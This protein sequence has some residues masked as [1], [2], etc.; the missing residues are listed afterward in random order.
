[1]SI[2]EAVNIS[3]GYRD[4][5]NILEGVN[6]SISS[7]ERV[8]IV[9][10]SGYGKSTFAKILAGYLK[11]R[12]G[13]I[14][15]DGKKIEKKGF[16]P[17]QLIYQHPEKSINPKWKIKKALSENS[18]PDKKLLDIL[19]V[20]D[21]WLERYPNELSGGELQRIA[22]ARAVT[23][24]TK[25]LIADEITAML[26]GITQAQIWHALIKL[27]IDQNIGMIIITHNIALAKRICTRI[28][29]LQEINHAP[30]KNNYK[31]I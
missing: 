5:E 8:G 20:K 9:A 29:H 22:I 24:N 14:R 27:S 2:L 3:F 30:M 6:F 19:G 31:A 15:L 7:D 18:P 4:E 1:M 28:V 11:P 10:E 25:F 26:D 17:V 23:K 21:I 12:S 13:E 16:Y